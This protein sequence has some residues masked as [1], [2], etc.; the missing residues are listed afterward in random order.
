MK[1]D[2]AYLNKRSYSF[3]TNII[4]YEQ[5][6]TLLVNTVFNI[7]MIDTCVEY[8][9]SLM[10]LTDIRVHNTLFRIIRRRIILA[11]KTRPFGL[12]PAINEENMNKT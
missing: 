9:V 12:A 6:V 2:Y 10:S 1:Y 5:V 7:I 8:S 3:K 4:K 11:L